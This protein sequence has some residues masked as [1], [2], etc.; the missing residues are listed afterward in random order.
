MKDIFICESASVKD[1]L[2]RLDKTA[3]KVL[4]I[5]DAENRLLGTITDGDIRRYIL[6]G[7]N[8][9]DDI[10]EVYNKSPF[11]IK[12]RD[13]SIEHIKEILIKN[14]VYLLPIVDEE[15]RII[16]FITWSQAFSEGETEPRKE[17]KID[18]PVVIM[19]GGEGTRLQPFTKIL[20]KPLIPVGD[21]PVIELIIEEFKRYGVR[22]YYLILN[23]KG[24]MIESYFSDAERDYKIGY[25]WEKEH[26]G[27]AGGLKI[28]EGM[29]SDIFIVSN[30]DVIVEADFEEVVNL[31]KEIGASMTILSSIQHYKIP[32]GVIKF[33]EKGVVSDIFEKPEY[34][35]A[36]NTGVYLLNRDS[37]RFIPENSYFDMIDLIKSLIESKRKVV[38]YPINGNDYTDTG[39]WEEYKKAV[40][41][42]Q[43]VK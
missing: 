19:A 13:S 31:H 16:D 17:S 21:K 9:E 15:R 42:L 39:Q 7:R 43:F 22:E 34:T 29:I 1:T 5:T 23:Y 25:V 38:T 4:L 18:I 8:L 35:F 27:T 32:Y 14:K 30:C 12:K 20:P 37:L 28:I 3:E 40:E 26:L 36:V 6:K 2:K 24:K 11:F 33:Q 41:K 10:R